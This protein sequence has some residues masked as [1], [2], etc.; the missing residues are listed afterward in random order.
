MG[1]IK[2]EIKA[3]YTVL[4]IYIIFYYFIIIII[5]IINFFL[6]ENILLGYLDD[7]YF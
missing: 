7:F 2:A 5:I 4:Y 6:P 3:F 1:N